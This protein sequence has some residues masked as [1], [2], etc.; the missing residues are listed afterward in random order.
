MNVTSTSAFVGATE[1]EQPVIA[2]NASKGA[3][4]SL[5]TDLAVKLAPHGIRVN[6]IAPGP[7]DTDMMS[8][9]KRDPTEYERYFSAVPL[10]RPG[11]EADI[12]GVVVFLASPAASFVTGQTLRVDGGMTCIAR[13]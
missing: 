8:W 3:V 9:L 4:V 10:G 6:A 12:K 13:A 5:T 1:E 2:Y 7:F 11:E